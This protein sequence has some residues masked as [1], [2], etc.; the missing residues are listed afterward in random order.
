MLFPAEKK[1]ALPYEGDLA[2]TEV[3]KFMADH[4]SNSHHL[5]SE[6]GNFI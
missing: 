3:F 2:V 6:K 1:H 4:G 5:I